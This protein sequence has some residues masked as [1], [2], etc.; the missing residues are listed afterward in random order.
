MRPVDDLLTPAEAAELLGISVKQLTHQARTRKVPVAVCS[1]GGHRRYSA[2][3][4]ARLAGEQAA[5]NTERELAVVAEMAGVP[6]EQV[7][8]WALVVDDG[9]S[10]ATVI[11]SM[12]PGPC[13][14]M[15]AEV[16]LIVI[17]GTTT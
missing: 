15:L 13:A 5:H 7:K 11:T 1:A 4:I 6:P 8:G 9:T 14:A 17:T 16:A 10:R 2:E 3:V 12:E